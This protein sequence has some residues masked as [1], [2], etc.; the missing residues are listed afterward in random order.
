MSKVNTKHSIRIAVNS[1]GYIRPLT[2]GTV[3]FYPIYGISRC[4]DSLSSC[5]YSGRSMWIRIAVI[6]II[7]HIQCLIPICIYL[8]VISLSGIDIVK[9]SHKCLG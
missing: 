3:G 9:L 7:I 8:F 2:V 1:P 4:K 5:L 6:M